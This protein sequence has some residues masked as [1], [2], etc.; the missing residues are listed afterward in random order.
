M[1]AVVAA[2]AAGTLDGIA[3]AQQPASITAEPCN[4]AI[5]GTYCATQGGRASRGASSSVNMGSIQS[6]SNDLSLGQ[7]SPATF[8]GVS[9]SSSSTT[10]IG[11]F[12]RASCN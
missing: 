11:L 2:L 7:D 1:A 12:R 8:A 10:C 4:P 9:F 3:T 6:L 5:D